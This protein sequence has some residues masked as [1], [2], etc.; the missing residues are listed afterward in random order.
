MKNVLFSRSFVNAERFWEAETS[1]T[2]GFRYEHE[3]ETVALK[4]KLLN[5]KAFAKKYWEYI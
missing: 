5:T 1:S 3:N 4:V 2:K